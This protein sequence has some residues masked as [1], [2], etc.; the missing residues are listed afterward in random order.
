M[1]DH[2][3]LKWEFIADP[4]VGL[5]I[6]LINILIRQAQVSGANKEDVL[7]ACKFVVAKLEGK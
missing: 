2:E 4:P 7:R 5:D 1:S 6:A 3:P